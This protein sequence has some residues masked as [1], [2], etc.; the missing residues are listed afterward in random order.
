MKYIVHEI[1]DD[2]NVTLVSEDTLGAEVNTTPPQPFNHRLDN[3][4][5]V[6]N[7]KS[8]NRQTQSSDVSFHDE[9]TEPG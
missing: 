3:L 5:P 9:S 7:S 2:S 4:G 1:Q 6:D 8:A